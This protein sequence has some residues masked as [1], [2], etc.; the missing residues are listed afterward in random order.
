M[1]KLITQYSHLNANGDN[2]SSGVGWDG[3]TRLDLFHIITKDYQQ[4]SLAPWA[5]GNMTKSN[6]LHAKNPKH[7]NTFRLEL[8]YE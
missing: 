1:V 6:W 4:K 2:F 5:A 8:I 7:L 3:A